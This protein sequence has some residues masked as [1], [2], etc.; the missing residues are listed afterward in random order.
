MHSENIVCFAKDW[1]ENPTSCTHVLKGLAR[2]NRVLWLNSIA[3]RVPNLASTRDLRTIVRKVRGFAQGPRDVGS[4]LTTLTPMVLPFPYSRGAAAL[5]RLILRRTIKRAR[6]RLG[7]GDF[8][9]WTF[10]PTASHLIGSLGESL[11]VYYCTDEWSQ[12]R[13]VDPVRITAQERE[14]C[15]KVD[16]IFA[17]A[18]RIVEKKR[19][20]NPET[21]LITHGV[22]RDHFAAA[23]SPR[24]VLPDDIAGLPRPVIGFF[25]LLEDWIDTELFAWLA[26]QR[27]SWSIV[28][29]G[30]S[31]IPL[32]H[33]EGIPNLHLLGRRPYEQLPSYAK[34]FSVA[35]CPFRINELTLHVNPIKLREYL[36]AGLPVV[37]SDLPECRIRE[38]WGRVGKSREEIL[39]HIEA[40]LRED[41]EEAR[42]AR[43]EAMRTETWDHKLAEIGG[44]VMRVKEAKAARRTAELAHA[45]LA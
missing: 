39:G 4:G 15:G 25:G 43:S 6:A 5:N 19:E 44:H 8:Q 18:R 24:T 41:S 27:P 21:H 42:H 13:T 23:L 30:Q 9:A 3:A 33:L 37:S 40:F 11:S 35:L 38:D 34:A 45:R 26:T 32:P 31:H 12:F 10:L 22:D 16:L 7:M 17:A 1:T 20:L 14:L 29:I 36:S 2:E 28:V